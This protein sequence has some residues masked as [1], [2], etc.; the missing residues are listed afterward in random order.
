LII[1]YIKNNKKATA[2]VISALLGLSNVRTRAILQKLVKNGK[3]KKISD[4]RYA[5]YILK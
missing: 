1:T 4:K 2:T 5:Y 3:I